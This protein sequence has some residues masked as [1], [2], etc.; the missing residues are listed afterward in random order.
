MVRKGASPRLFE[1]GHHLKNTAR[2]G[3]L[4]DGKLKLIQVA[5]FSP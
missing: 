1:G 5:D 2:A 4:P 3:P